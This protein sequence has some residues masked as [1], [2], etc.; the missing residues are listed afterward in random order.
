MIVPNSLWPIILLSQRDAPPAQIA[1]DHGV[2]ARHLQISRELGS[3]NTY[4]RHHDIWPAKDHGRDVAHVHKAPDRPRRSETTSLAEGVR[5]ARNEALQ[6][7]NHDIGLPFR[8]SGTDLAILKMATVSSKA[9]S[10]LTVAAAF[11]G[12]GGAH[13]RMT[14]HA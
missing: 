12:A 8:P 4:I 13:P 2:A 5:P 11:K 1:A 9:H 6:T 14:P 3:C 10:F 7:R